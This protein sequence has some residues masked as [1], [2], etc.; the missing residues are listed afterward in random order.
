MS[1]SIEERIAYLQK[2]A[3]AYYNDGTS[4]LTDAEYDAEYDAL[5]ELVPD[6][7]FFEEVGADADLHIYGT[8][9]K[10]QVIM[11]SLCKSKN[12]NDFLIWLKTIY[13]GTIEVVLEHKVDGLSLGCVYQNGKLVRAIT[14]GDSCRV[15]RSRL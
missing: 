14:R 3:K 1:K 12:V 15:V 13:S 5:Q 2:C 6:N 11:G 8:K 10:H 7:P 9:V 4:E